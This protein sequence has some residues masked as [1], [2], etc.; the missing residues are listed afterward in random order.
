M[1][2]QS[3]PIEKKEAQSGASRGTLFGLQQFAYMEIGIFFV[4]MLPLDFL[5]FEGNRFADA[6]PHPFWLIV[7]LTSVQFGIREGL[8]AVG[9][10]TVALLAFNVGSPAEGQGLIN[11][12][13][14]LSYHPLSWMAISVVL[15]GLRARQIRQQESLKRTIDEVE[16][17]L[18]HISAAYDD[19][20]VQKNKLEGHV[21]GQLSTAIELYRTARDVEKKEP[22]K[23]IVGT[24]G[25][26]N[27]ILNPK[28]VSIFLLKNDMLQAGIQNGW[29]DSDTYQRFFRSESP[30][31]Q[32]IVA[33]KRFLNVS[34]LEDEQLLLGQGVLAGPLID[35]QTGEISG[36]LKIEKMAF[37]NLNLSS[38]KSFELL[39]EWIGTLLARSNSLRSVD[40]GQTAIPGLQPSH[41]FEPHLAFL[42]SLSNRLSFDATLVRIQ[43]KNPQELDG[44]M[45]GNTTVLVGRVVRDALRQ[46][47]YCFD[48]QRG[49]SYM[50]LL[51]GTPTEGARVVSEKVRKGMDGVVK[52]IPKLSFFVEVE[53]IA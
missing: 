3:N 9:C 37:L 47:D 45:L 13:F 19:L 49:W 14:S 42:K 10:S 17:K 50:I 6:N 36:M 53:K 35:R 2:E 39:C 34:R 48:Y 44:D 8:L 5:L 52:E 21:A 15:G 20:N 29:D 28:K 51:P 11:H 24:L 1:V 31:F 46:T 27:T 18:D 33:Q 22:A 25:L 40:R 32:A 16:E 38:V 4:L 30:L 41:L 12:L 23:I 7:L 26:V 43:I